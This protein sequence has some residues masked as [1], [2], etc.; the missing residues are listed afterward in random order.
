MK[1]F[2]LNKLGNEVEN[3][4]RSNPAI[5]AVVISDTYA[6]GVQGRIVIKK[7]I[8]VI[9]NTQAKHTLPNT[10]SIPLEAISSKE[11]LI[12]DNYWV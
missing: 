5:N 1:I 10:F 6:T 4:L 12:A 7:G 3:F 9:R 11:S 8:W 2:D